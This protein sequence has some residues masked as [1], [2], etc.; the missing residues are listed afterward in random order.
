MIVQGGITLKLLQSDVS[1]CIAL[2]KAIW[3]FLRQYDRIVTNHIG[4]C[5]SDLSFICMDLLFP[6]LVYHW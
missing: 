3:K 5:F 4:S 1:G 6:Q 2:A